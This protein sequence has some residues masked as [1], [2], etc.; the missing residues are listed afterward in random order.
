MVTHQTFL[1][2]I[3]KTLAIGQRDPWVSGTIRLRDEFAHRGSKSVM[4][5]SKSNKFG[6]RKLQQSPVSTINNESKKV[7]TRIKT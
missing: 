1:P 2:D 5:F 6:L 4:G 7:K 3:K